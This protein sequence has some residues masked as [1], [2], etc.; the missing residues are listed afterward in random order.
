M[1]KLDTCVYF[2]LDNNKKHDIQLTK[3]SQL[4]KIV[5][6]DY[7]IRN[8]LTNVLKIQKINNY[9]QFFYVFENSYALDIKKSNSLKPD[10]NLLL[11]FDNC[12]LKYLKDYLQSLSSPKIYIL[13][14][15]LIYKYLLNSIQLLVNNNI[16]HNHI[17]FGSISINKEFP[18]LTD[19]SFSISTDVSF[20]NIKPF[21]IEYDPSYLE[22]PIEIHILTFLITNKLNS[23]SFFN[24]EHIITEV[25][26]NHSILKTF[27]PQV[28][29]VYKEEAINF[30]KKY[31][32]QSYDYILTDIF[33]YSSTWDNYALSILFLRILI[34]IHRTI[35][36]QN[37]FIIGFMKLLVTN[38]H[39]NPLKRF[40]I[41][42]TTNKFEAILETIEPQEYKQLF[43]RIK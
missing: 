41:I 23:L 10:N 18:L 27:G 42:T 4:H 38:I 15:I 37:N 24:I 34:G 25:V 30:F 26:E 43:S 2:F 35:D 14:I 19:F 1:E 13:K 36:I 11:T 12:E 40:S 28:V 6:N 20:N 32:N 9:K 31:I 7:F 5:K 21:F 29:S 22:W 17:Q 3:K 33:L 16:V 8:E 39:L